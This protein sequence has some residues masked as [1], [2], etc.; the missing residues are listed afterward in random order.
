MAK[1]SLTP[2]QIAFAESDERFYEPPADE[3]L[4][5]LEEESDSEV[6]AEEEE[7]DDDVVAEA[8]SDEEEVQPEE[9]Q[10]WLDD[11]ARAYAK[12]YGLSEGDLDKY[13]SMEELQRFGELTDRRI[14]EQT[15]FN[16][17]QQ[18]EPL[19]QEPE[20]EDQTG[21][22]DGLYDVQKLIDENYDET[23]VALGKALRDTQQ[24]VK[25]MSAERDKAT[26]TQNL[27]RE[28]EFAKKFHQSLDAFDKGLFGRVFDESENVGTISDPH[29]MNRRA[30]WEAATRIHASMPAEAQS[31]DD[32]LLIKRAV[33]M[34]FG[35]VRIDQT[36][37][38]RADKAKSQSRK[39][40]PT[41]S[42]RNMNKTAAVTPDQQ[43]Q[44][45]VS[46]IARSP[47]LRKFW[48]KSQRD[49]GVV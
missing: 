7:E 25:Q 10:S 22:D 2:S 38:S 3:Q 33:N 20:A 6:E 5:E 24:L 13:S 46:A 42:G 4:S 11:D 40:R 35:D 26:E 18:R 19:P 27:Q 32:N 1:I 44:D 17:Y 36:S 29:D 30:V 37:E 12:S 34:A 21:S 48:E 28:A 14:K 8:D 41:S 31:M 45:D 49:N 43:S 47:E 23:T 9:T 16:Q 39:R 15:Q